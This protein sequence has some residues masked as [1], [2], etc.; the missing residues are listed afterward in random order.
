MSGVSLF[1]R[2]T[3]VQARL[4]VMAVAVLVVMLVVRSFGG[5]DNLEA[6]LSDYAWT[7]TASES[8]E[9]RLV[10]V[11]ID[12]KT[13]TEI[14]PWPWSRDTFA[15]LSDKLQALG[16]SH[17]VFDVVFPD[18][19][20]GDEALAQ[21][22]ERNNAVIGQLPELGRAMGSVKG[23]LEQPLE[24]F[25]C[26][27]SFSRVT[28][29]LGNAAAFAAVSKGH[30]AA[31]I[32]TDGAI[33]SV[34]AVVCEGNLAYPSLAVRAL[35]NAFGQEKLVLSRESET[36]NADYTLGLAEL[37]GLSFPL[38]SRGAMRV[39]FAR[40]PEMFQ[41]VSASDVLA[42]NL[43][44]GALAGKWVLVGGTA[45]GLSDFVP[46]PFSG[47]EPGVLLQARLLTSLLDGVVPFVPQ[48]VWMVRLLELMGAAV[49]ILLVA[50]V[51]GRLWQFML[52][53][54][55]VML[56]ALFLY[57]HAYILAQHQMWVG[58]LESVMSALA[59]VVAVGLY[60]HGVIRFERSRLY[61]NLSSYLPKDAA[62]T[63]AL[64]LPS[65]A[66][67]ARRKNLILMSAD[68][69]NFSAYEE[70]R[71]PEET[72]A[73]LHCFFTEANAVVEQSGGEIQEFTADS[74]IA[75]WPG[76]ETPA[77]VVLDAASKV[78]ER[79]ESFLPQSP[80]NGLEPLALGI[81]I[82]QGAVLV[83]SIGPSTRRTHTL[84]GDTVSI[85][86]RIQEMTQEL[87]QP[88][89]VGEAFAR[90]YGKSGLDTQ[91]TFLLPGSQRP[92]LLYAPIRTAFPDGAKES[93]GDASGAVVSLLSSK[94]SV[95]R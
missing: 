17:Q 26:P 18:A 28:G 76:G 69:R 44:K 50:Q 31:S 29:V 57:L 67:E 9:E 25:S 22:L 38:D 8:L 35:T 10:I 81:G 77:E 24:D 59:M 83:G 46:T 72:A 20:E 74:F 87:A 27:P 53:A 91:G 79:I 6:R 60:E 92:Q 47:N 55:G 61:H 41:V 33:R 30:I 80:P 89:L 1:I 56:P 21:T 34:P 36:F 4:V 48:S 73:L 54:V 16:V 39:S 70:S 85:V 37:P 11:A 78:L 12:E 15:S 23:A 93:S 86:V 75:A 14:G 13:L 64:S 65:G 32:D 84:L 2:L 63:I 52:P 40:P 3:Q 51:K 68:L 62:M 19:K 95:S 49:I 88:I 7:A 42:G 45:F 90:A 71:P 43:S 94:R 82:E 5:V 58:W 66:V